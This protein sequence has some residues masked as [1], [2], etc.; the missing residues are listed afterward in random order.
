MPDEYQAEAL[1]E[2]EKLLNLAESTQERVDMMSRRI[3]TLR[4]A[5]GFI[6]LLGVVAGIIFSSTSSDTSMKTLQGVLIPALSIGYGAGIEYMMT[7]RYVQ[8]RK[9]DLRALEE[10]VSLARETISGMA[11][12]EKWST[13]KQVEFRIRL[14]RFDVG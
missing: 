2:M 1:D 14:S 8:R 5:T 11:K 7:R 13:L 4:F 6:V 9:R 3:A 10:L 12:R